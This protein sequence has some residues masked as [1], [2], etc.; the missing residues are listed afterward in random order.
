MN[1][2]CQYLE[3]YPYT[4]APIEYFT[5]LYTIIFY[6]TSNSRHFFKIPSQFQVLQVSRYPTQQYIISYNQEYYKK[7][8]HYGDLNLSL[9]IPAETKKLKTVHKIYCLAC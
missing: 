4:Y 8:I 9:G 3:N 7:G 1:Y 6:Y 5:I 2:R